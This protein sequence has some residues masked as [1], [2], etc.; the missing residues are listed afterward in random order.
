M[1]NLS[2]AQP[3][4]DEALSLDQV[5][6]A[7]PD[8]PCVL[9]EITLNIQPGERLGVIGPN[10]AGKTTLF[11][12]ICGVLRPSSGAVRLFGKRVIPGEFRP[13]VGL[14]FQNPNDQLFCP[15]VWDDVAFGVENLGY[16]EAEVAERVT[17]T[18]EQLGI[19][20]YRDRPPHH[21]SGGQKRMVAIAGVLAMQPQ[22]ILYDEPSA[23]LDLRSRR[24][25]I[26]FLHQASQTL[27]I[28]SHDLELILELCDRLILLDEGTVIADGS[29][30]EIMSDRPLMEAHGL[31]KPSGL[32]SHPPR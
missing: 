29:P 18:L 30:V 19:L 6:F 15:S 16:G 1:A 20:E 2:P 11:L 32:L 25:L 9:N 22:L 24:R 5:V 17:Q 21:L 26:E 27:I 3:C 14:V 10:G 28:A 31:E 7:Y 12:T 8:V 23:N 13:E 4:E